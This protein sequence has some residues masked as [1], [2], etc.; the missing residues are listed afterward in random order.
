VCLTIEQTAKALLGSVRGI[1]GESDMHCHA[2]GKSKHID[3]LY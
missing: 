3:A 2:W 1:G